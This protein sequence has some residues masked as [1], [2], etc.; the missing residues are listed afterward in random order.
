[1]LV[2]TSLYRERIAPCLIRCVEMDQPHPDSRDA[3]RARLD[4]ESLRAECA[5]RSLPFVDLGSPSVAGGGLVNGFPPRKP[6]FHEWEAALPAYETRDMAGHIHKSHILGGY[7]TRLRNDTELDRALQPLRDGNDLVFDIAS[8]FLNLL[9]I[10]F[11]CFAT[12]HRGD[13]LDAIDFEDVFGQDDQ[14]QIEATDEDEPFNPRNT[15]ILTTAYAV[16]DQLVAGRAPRSAFRVY[17][18]A[19]PLHLYPPPEGSITLDTFDMSLVVRGPNGR[20]ETSLARDRVGS[21]ERAEML[22]VRNVLAHLRRTGFDF[23]PYDHAAVAGLLTNP[24]G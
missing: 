20:R 7:R 9:D 10:F 14:Q 24:H 11:M 19:N 17:C 4:P 21:Q 6:P 8:S 1:M 13:T 18:T 16:H 12:W 3:C 5:A 15:R 23:R 22:W 2:P